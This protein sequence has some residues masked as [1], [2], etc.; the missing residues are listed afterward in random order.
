MSDYDKYEYWIDLSDYDLV[1]AKDMLKSK[2]Y[3]YVGFMCHQSVEKALKAVFVRDYPP[4]NLP[5]MHDLTKI[6]ESSAVL[7]KLSQ[8]QKGFLLELK[9]LN[10]E[11]RYPDAKTRLLARLTYDYCKSLVA[12]AEELVTW[13]KVN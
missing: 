1:V 10:I 5:Y 3:L 11:A 9:P 8:E 13:L 4:E 6:A 7:N 2:H 12:R